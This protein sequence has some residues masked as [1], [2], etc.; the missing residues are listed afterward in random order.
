MNNSVKM[1]SP[2]VLYCQKVIP[3]A[4]DESMSYYECL[5]ALYSYLKDTVVPAVNNNAEALE[6]VQKAM[7]E[8]KEYV[9]T[10][11]DNL[12]IQTEV[13]NKLDEMAE[14]GELAEIIAQFL[15]MQFIYGFDTISDMQGGDNYVE[16]SIV[17]TLGE[18][19]Y[20]DGKGAFYRI[21]QLRI[22]DVIDGVNIV[23][24]TNFPSL[25]AEKIPVDISQFVD[26]D[27]YVTYNAE[28]LTELKCEYNEDIKCYYELLKLKKD[29]FSLSQLYESEYPNGIYDYLKNTE[30][31]FYMNGVLSG[32]NVH[33]GVGISEAQSGSQY[34]Y[35]LGLNQN[36]EIVYAKDLNRS[37]TTSGLITLGY[38]EAFGIWSPVIINGNAFVPATEI[39]NTQNDYDYIINHKHPRTILGYD[40]DYYYLL[41]IEGRLANSRGATFSEIVTLCQD[42]GITNAFNLDGGGSTQLWT[43]KN[44]KNLVFGKEHT[45]EP[46][47]ARHLF[48]G[49]KFTK[50]D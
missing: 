48:A 1:L 21:R 11:F 32:V 39:P 4:F 44:P 40:D 10:Y 25:V 22:D 15:E 50:E 14:S 24:L 6:E 23:S 12:D 17:K 35:V 2:F 37:L 27:D 20:D 43:S 38:K 16:G 7:T 26:L 42:L 31:C 5:C 33:N 18:S 45:T 49:L 13:N 9:D 47:T 29:K 8:L 46:Y 30:N 28:K 41:T 19:A 3:L 36:N 34:W